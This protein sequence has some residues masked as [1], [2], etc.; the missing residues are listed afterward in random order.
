MTSYRNRSE[1]VAKS[2]ARYE[3]RA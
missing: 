3:S 1:L 2:S